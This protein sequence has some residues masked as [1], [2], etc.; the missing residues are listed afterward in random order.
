MMFTS[1]PSIQVTNVID[2]SC[3]LDDR[4]IVKQRFSWPMQTVNT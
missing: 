2:L 1:V 3:L 4:S